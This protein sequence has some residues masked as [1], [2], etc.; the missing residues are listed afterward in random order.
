M[1]VKRMVLEKAPACITTHRCL[2]R[3]TLSTRH[4]RVHLCQYHIWKGE[5]KYVYFAKLWI[6]Q[7]QMLTEVSDVVAGLVE[8]SPVELEPDDG[9]DDDGKEKEEGDVDQ[10]ADGLCNGGHHHLQTWGQKL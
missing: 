1:I 6:F 5:V 3:R 2:L 9:K 4:S 8:G 10:G 7:R